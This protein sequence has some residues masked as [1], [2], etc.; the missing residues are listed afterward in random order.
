MTLSPVEERWFASDAPK[1]C[2]KCSP[3]FLNLARQHEGIRRQVIPREEELHSL[4]WE[5]SDPLSEERFS[6]LPRMVHRY[7]NRVAVLVTD[8]C[9]VHCRHCFRRAFTGKNHHDL[10]AGEQENI[11]SYLKEHREVREV[12]LTGGD[13]LTLGDAQLFLLLERFRECRS[14][15]VLRLGTRIPS[16]LP[17]RISPKTARELGGFAPLWLII[18]FNHPAEL[19]AESRRALTLLRES[20]VPMVSQTVLLR[21]INDD[22]GTLAELFQ[23]LLTAGVKPYY[24]FQGDLAA[25]TSHL[26]VPLRRGWE[27]MDQLRTMVS[28]LALPRYA[29]DLPGGGGKIPLDRSLMV[30]ENET[31]YIFRNGEGREFTYPREDV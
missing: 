18:H 2:F 17:G 1:L 11:I 29:V 27:I 5:S 9:A 12:L 30:G 19:T 6:P 24:L 3:Y 4:P 15:L 28:G 20:G 14:D 13:P 22:A 8:R 26:R 31:G 23:Q 7:P 21:G 25:G 16:V 10:T